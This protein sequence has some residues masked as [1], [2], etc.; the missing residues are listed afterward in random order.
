LNGYHRSSH[1]VEATLGDVVKEI[2]DYSLLTGKPISIEKL[3]FSKK[4]AKLGEESKQYSR[5]LSGFTYHKFGDYLKSRALKCG[6]EV[7]EVSPAYTS[8]IGQLKFMKRYGLSSH[9]SA[10]CVIARR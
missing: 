5:M 3:D 8:I 1:Q 9:A 10:A 7:I 6:V 4:K 2:V